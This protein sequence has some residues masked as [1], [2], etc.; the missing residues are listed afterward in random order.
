MQMC[1][2]VAVALHIIC[3]KEEFLMKNKFFCIALSLFLLFLTKTP[4]SYAQTLKTSNFKNNTTRQQPLNGEES[5]NIPHNAIECANSS[6]NPSK[7]PSESA[8]NISAKSAYLIDFNTQT[9]LFAHNAEAKLPIASMC[10]IMTLLL[11]FEEIKVG[12]LSLDNM[13]FVS[14]NA[15]SMGG[16]Q[17]FL[18]E[19]EEYLLSDLIKSIIISSANDSCVAIAE[20][21]CGSTDVFVEKMNEKAK[22]IGM[23]NTV[24][25]NCTGLPKPG[26]FS[27]A[28]DVA[29]MMSELLHHP[30]YFNFSS[31]WMD[32]INHKDG[33]YTE[34]TNTNKLIRAFS[35]CDGGKTG[36]TA[37]AKYCLSATAARDNLRLISVIIGAQ[38]SKTRFKE[39][40]NLLNYGFANYKNEK[41]LSNEVIPSIF[42]PIKG[43]KE[44]GVSVRPQKEIFLL[45]ARKDKPDVRFETIFHKGIKAPVKAGQEVGT[46]IAYC[47][48]VEID[49]TPVLAADSV[50]KKSFKDILTQIIQSFASSPLKIQPNPLKNKPY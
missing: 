5:E 2:Y 48:G 13:V 50:N 12:N 43:G 45:S 35:G 6:E 28:K 41:I 22:E 15:S 30:A 1:E 26:Q 37:E 42:C 38:D 40:S 25:T 23:N 31:I 44:N 36:Y 10:K 29:I 46:I 47:N 16:S 34:L 21:I 27:C 3:N 9:P 20:K 33:T 14:E 8:L 24:F 39:N 18:R 7:T 49:R 32:K 19:N 17:A 4:L 11:T